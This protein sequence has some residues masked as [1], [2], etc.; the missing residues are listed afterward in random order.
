VTVSF[1]D[2]PYLGVWHWP[3]KDAPYVCIEPW[4]SLP[5]REGKTAVLEEQADLIRLDPGK[6]YVNTW[7]IA[8]R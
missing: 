6:T 1:P 8:V 4:A 3:K 2:M 7:M 5:S